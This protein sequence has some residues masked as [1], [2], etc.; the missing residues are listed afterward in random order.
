L[1][2][3]WAGGLAGSEVADADAA[4][5]IEAEDFVKGEHDRRSSRDDRAANDRHLALVNIAAPDGEA[6]V[7]DSGDAKDEPEH[8]DY[9]QTVADAGLEVRGI[10]TGAA[11]CLRECGNGVEDQDRGDRDE[12]RKSRANFDGESFC[13]LHSV[14]FYFFFVARRLCRRIME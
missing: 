5:R 7:D 1:G 12:R 8:H 2:D 9:G 13:E 10:E 11:A 3:G 6:A 14:G 4:V